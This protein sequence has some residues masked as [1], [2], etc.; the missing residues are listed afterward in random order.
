MGPWGNG[1]KGIISLIAGTGGQQDDCIVEELL[2]AGEPRCG[3]AEEGEDSAEDG[4]TSFDY[5]VNIR[6]GLS[7]KRA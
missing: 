5:V 3:T 1:G 4:Q 7:K 6:T 2:T